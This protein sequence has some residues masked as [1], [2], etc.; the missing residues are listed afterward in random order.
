MFYIWNS[1]IKTS[2]CNL[3]YH[4]QWNQGLI[5]GEKFCFRYLD[6]Y[7]WHG[8]STSTASQLTSPASQNSQ[9]I[10]KVSPLLQNLDIN[11]WYLQHIHTACAR[12][13]NGQNNNQQKTIN[14]SLWFGSNF[15][16]YFI[17]IWFI[18]PQSVDQLGTHKPITHFA[19]QLLLFTQPKPTIYHKP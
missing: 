6:F 16:E 13:L 19:S 3:N 15:A 7:F 10:N 17:I 9:D 2:N 11:P 18:H 1:V 14:H 4:N 12:F 8:E 5:K